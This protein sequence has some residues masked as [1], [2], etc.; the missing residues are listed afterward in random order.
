VKKT[1]CSRD[2]SEELEPKDRLLEYESSLVSQD[3][4]GGTAYWTE[5]RKAA[6]V[7]VYKHA[8]EEPKKGVLSK[9]K[10]M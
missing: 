2:E 9:S 8:E 3:Y 5:L 1:T 7:R 6:L 4:G 10:S